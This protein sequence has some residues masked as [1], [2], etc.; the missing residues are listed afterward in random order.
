MTSP[1]HQITSLCQSSYAQKLE[2]I[3]FN[4]G[5]RRMS[6][7]EVIGGGEGGG[8]LQGARRS[9]KAK[10]SPVWIGICIWGEWP[11]SGIS[12][13]APNKTLAKATRHITNNGRVWMGN[14]S[15]QL[16]K[17]SN[18]AHQQTIN[19]IRG[20]KNINTAGGGRIHQQWISWGTKQITVQGT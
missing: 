5:G 20:N 13:I 12:A 4:F 9:Q 2:I 10:K 8:G 16:A 1:W 14:Q 11:P 3:V 15:T 7:F 17:V 18:L 6:G 19:K